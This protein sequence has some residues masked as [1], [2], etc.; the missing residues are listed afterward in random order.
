MRAR[1]LEAA[2]GLFLA[3]GYGSTSIEAVASRAGISK[4]TF[5]HRFPDKAAL[6][7]AVVHDIISQIRPPPEVPLL[8]GA[9]L[10][11]VLRRLA[12]MMLEAALSAKAIALHRLVMAESGRFPELA[13]AV[14][15]DDSAREA[16]ELI[17][18]LLSRELG[19]SKLGA[20]QL[21]FAAQQFIVMVVN[22]PQRRAMGYG[23]PMT[24]AELDS[25]AD[26]VVRLFLRGCEGLTA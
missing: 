9:T 18:G 4:R 5:Y 6:F 15:S 19:N 8:A 24:P 16:T 3:E 25:W 23:A 7:A 1:I 22:W 26:Q 20:P 11:E 14:T 2:T 12:R 21:A 10:H 17:G 13:R